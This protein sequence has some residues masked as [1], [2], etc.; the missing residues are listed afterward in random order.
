MK[1]YITH[2]YLIAI[3]I[4]LSNEDASGQTTFQ[5]TFGT[6]GGY[7]GRCSVQQTTDGGYVISGGIYANGT[8]GVDAFLMKTNSNGD[9]TWSKT[10]GSSNIEWAIDA[11]QTLDGGYIITG[12]MEDQ[13]R[14]VFL[15][16]T[17]MNGDTVWVRRFEANYLSFFWGSV[18]A[19]SDGG[20]ATAFPYS[21]PGTFAIHLAKTDQNGNLLWTKEY[22]DLTTR[23][24]PYSI[25]E[26]SDH[27][28]I[29][30]GLESP[31]LSSEYN[32]ILIKADSVGNVE[33]SK[34]YGTDAV[35]EVAYD[36]EQT[37]DGGYIVNAF[38]FGSTLLIRT[39]SVGDTLWTR[40]FGVY[41]NSFF[42]ASVRQ[43]SDD[44]F[45]LAGG[46]GPIGAGT[47][48]LHL[49]KT[50]SGGDTLW[51]RSIGSTGFN[52]AASSIQETI[53][54]GF[55]IA[56]GRGIYN[57]GN[58]QIYVAETDSFGHVGCDETHIM[59][60]VDIDTIQVASFY[61]PT[62]SLNS[63]A[64][65]FQISQGTFGNEG[66]LCYNA[67]DDPKAH[68]DLNVY[69]NPFHTS[70]IIILPSQQKIS[71]IKLFDEYGREVSFNYQSSHQG[72][73]TQLTIERENLASGM[74]FLSIT[75]NEKREVVKLMI[76]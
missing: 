49:V 15:L 18:V 62:T 59:T 58:Y 53:S 42:A 31:S 63:A 30:T 41:P 39:N 25:H 48:Y 64:S 20:Y 19:T 61:V 4:S 2:L 57:A 27:G 76:E 50:N 56:G 13:S 28:F 9:V 12:E 60:A 44:G 22:G 55:I 69:S 68:E 72:S 6:A 65:S 24:L 43:T 36:V 74:Y 38:A 45:I 17:D 71:S 29:I 70:A 21:L 75:S 5:K 23:L 33:W 14:I 34:T 66:V 26:T 73:K 3:F 16:K 11:K 46:I 7:T 47:G 52:T 51:T 8:T 10:Y 54:K 67:V 1:N 35:Q 40:L 37:D 32:V